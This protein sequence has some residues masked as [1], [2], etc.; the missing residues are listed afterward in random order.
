M[1]P[2][3]TLLC[4]A[5]IAGCGEV[6]RP[7]IEAK[8]FDESE[9]LKYESSDPFV[10]LEVS[11]ILPPTDLHP[12]W[13]DVIGEGKII[14][15]Y[16]DGVPRWKWDGTR[17]QEGG[18]SSPTRK[19][20]WP[21]VDAIKDQRDSAKRERDTLAKQLGGIYRRLVELE[22]RAVICDAEGEKVEASNIRIGDTTTNPKSLQ[23]IDREYRESQEP[24]HHEQ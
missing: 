20:Q 24:P 3:L 12:Y 21:L 17:W 9:V 4:L 2:I 23:E 6:Q 7:D 18:F 1:K 19:H 8:A 10:D 15:L 13:R 16:V 22:K 5:A 14:E 11:P